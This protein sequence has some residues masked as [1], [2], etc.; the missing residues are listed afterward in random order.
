MGESRAGK[1][2]ILR[3]IK[4]IVGAS[5]VTSMDFEKLVGQHGTSALVGKSVMM[6]PDVVLTRDSHKALGLILAIS[7]GDDVSVNPK[8]KDLT[9]APLDVRMV[10]ATNE[11][12]S[13]P[14]R[15]GA[16]A[17]RL[18]PLVFTK[19]FRDNPDIHLADRIIANELPGILH[20]A[21]EGL[22]RLEANGAFTM[23]EASTKTLT[24][25]RHQA[26]PVNMF[27]KERC[28]IEE[29]AVIRKADMWRAFESY[30]EEL[31]IQNRFIP[32]S[33]GTVLMRN[34]T[35]FFRVEADRGVIDGRRVTIYR[36]IRLKDEF[37]KQLAEDE[38]D[39]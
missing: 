20:W 27:V 4:A 32:E 36:G 15:S 3:I 21:L 24:A 11:T 25:I 22:H 39:Y 23:P 33:F 30:C 16:F 34:A 13:L 17:N 12:M 14:D 6:I 26:G 2:V 8:F 31:D 37:A 18:H 1:G 29:G 35:G 28:V 5:N 7:G 38:D 10:L 19:T 9:S